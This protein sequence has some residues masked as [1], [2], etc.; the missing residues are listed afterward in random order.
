M[1]GQVTA[2]Q[3]TKVRPLQYDSLFLITTLGASG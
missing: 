2:H 3:I 1:L